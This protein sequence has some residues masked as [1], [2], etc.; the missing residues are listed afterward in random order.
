[1]AHARLEPS[2]RHVERLRDQ[3]LFAFAGIGR[4]EKFFTTL[5]RA[6]LTVVGRKP[7]PDHHAF[8]A[9]DLKAIQTEAHKAGGMPITTAKDRVR[10]PAA[11]ATEVLSVD[12]VF[13]DPD[14]MTERLA[15]LFA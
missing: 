12:L 1:V 8:T 4:P 3:P 13:D 7:F 6:G 10:L 5:E 2:P 9:D 15:A 14:E 11:F